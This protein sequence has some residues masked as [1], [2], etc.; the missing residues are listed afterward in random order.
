MRLAVSNLMLPAFDHL[1]YLPQLRAHG[2]EGLEIAPDH[3]WR[4]PPFGCGFD[5]R[6]VAAYGQAA[7]RAG[8]DI[9]GMHALLGGRLELGLFE[10]ADTRNQT[11]LHLVH[12][13]EVCRDLGGR[14]LILDS[15]WA[16]ELETKEAWLQCRAFLEKLLPRIEDHRTVL[17]FAPLVPEEGDFCRRA[18]ELLMLVSALDHASFGLHISTAALS[19][20]G[21][22]GHVHF[23]ARRGRLDH[24]HIDEPGRVALGSTGKVNHADMRQHLNAISYDGWLSVVQRLMPGASTNQ[25]I[26]ETTRDF[27]AIYR[28]DFRKRSPF[29][30]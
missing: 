2:V 17:C 30:V 16:R 25:S 4:R 13:S 12:L 8:L 3:T 22:T 20:N 18:N 29:H 21:E 9:V 15:R 28:R 6:R 14:T 5:S 19:A 26:L 7:R 11:I 24:V 27:K 23:A 1:G 10:D